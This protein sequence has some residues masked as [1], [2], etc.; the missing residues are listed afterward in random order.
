VA[1]SS[2]F[3]KLSLSYTPEDTSN[4]AAAFSAIPGDVKYPTEKLVSDM[5]ISKVEAESEQ[6]G[7]KPSN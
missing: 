2:I 7:S 4:K 1:Q 3:N 5:F 6:V